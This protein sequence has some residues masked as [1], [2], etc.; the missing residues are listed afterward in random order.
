MNNRF[1]DTAY[2]IALT[3]PSDEAH[4]RAV[5]ETASFSGSVIT[6]SA[7]L[8]ELANHLCDPPNRV[9]FVE[10]VERL[11]KNQKSR[12]VHVDERLFASGIA[13]YAARTDKHWSLTDCISFAV[14]KEFDLIDALTTDKHFQQA[15]FNALLA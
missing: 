12:V 1:A 15:G 14:M 3:N 13:L 10:I 6:T 11:R 8:N 2:F 5:R 7:V 9:L 4:A